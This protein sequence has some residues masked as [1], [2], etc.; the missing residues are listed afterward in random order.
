MI[1]RR[2]SH[3]MKAERKSDNVAFFEQIAKCRCRIIEKELLT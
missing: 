1:C 2:E 3:C